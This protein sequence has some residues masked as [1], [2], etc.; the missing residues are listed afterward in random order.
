MTVH[1]FY[2]LRTNHPTF[3]SEDRLVNFVRR[4]EC[5]VGLS[6]LLVYGVKGPKALLCISIRNICHIIYCTSTCDLI[7][8][9][10]YFDVNF[11]VLKLV[12]MKSLILLAWTFWVN[13][14]VLCMN[15]ILLK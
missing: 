6:I 1:I 15:L 7:I 4:R 14:Y 2:N 12:E 10:F 8:K 13:V 3:H 11:K 5:F 9:L